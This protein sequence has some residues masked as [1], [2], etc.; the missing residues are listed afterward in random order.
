VSLRS[1]A[2]VCGCSI[3][4]IAGS[5]PAERT[6]IGLLCLLCVV[7][8]MA[9]A[10]RSSF[11]GVLQGVRDLETSTMRQITPANGHSTAQ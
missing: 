5:N 2:C 8:V 9:P 1:K 3:A 4:R 11:R 10:T 6:D 7:Q